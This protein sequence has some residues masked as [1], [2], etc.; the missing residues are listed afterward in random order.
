MLTDKVVLVEV[1]ITK[2]MPYSVWRKVEGH[3]CLMTYTIGL[4]AEW[5]WYTLKWQTETFFF[6]C[7]IH[8]FGFVETHEQIVLDMLS[9]IHKTQTTQ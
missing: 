9:F 5:P 4:R 6:F 8:I 2:Q 1:E 7:V 3:D